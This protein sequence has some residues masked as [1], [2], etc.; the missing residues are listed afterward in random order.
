MYL[1]LTCEDE[2]DLKPLSM[3]Q[4]LAYSKPQSQ[5]WMCNGSGKLICFNEGY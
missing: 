2:K 1:M 4:L 5:I 3:V